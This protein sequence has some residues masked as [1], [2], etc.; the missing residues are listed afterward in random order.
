MSRVLVFVAVLM[1]AVTLFGRSLLE[2][3][4]SASKPTPQPPAVQARL[5]AN[6]SRPSRPP[7]PPAEQRA[8]PRD[9][10]IAAISSG[11]L[12]ARTQ[13][14][15]RLLFAERT[16]GLCQAVQTELTK[17]PSRFHA[18]QLLCIR[19]L[20]PG[21]DV[22]SRVIAAIPPASDTS[23]DIEDR[24]RRDCLLGAVAMRATEAPE[25]ALGP[26]VDYALTD[27][28][29]YT[30][31]ALR[32]LE[33]LEVDAL[34]AKIRAA[35]A[36]PP[37]SPDSL[38]S[39]LDLT[40]AAAI[41]AAIKLNAARIAPD[42]LT[43]ALSDP[44]ATVRGMAWE[45]LRA[46]PRP[47]TARF[48]A[49]MVIALPAAA[50][51]IAFAESGLRSEPLADVI[52]RR[53]DSQDFAPAL[54]D[55]ALDEQVEH[56]ARLRALELLARHGD[57]PTMARVAA[58]ST[59]ADEEL[60]AYARAAV[61]ERRPP[62][63][64]GM[65]REIEIVIKPDEAPGVLQRI[66]S[67]WKTPDVER[68]AAL[69][70][71]E[72]VR[73]NADTIAI[74]P[75]GTTVV[76]VSDGTVHIGDRVIPSRGWNTEVDKLVVTPAG[77]LVALIREGDPFGIYQLDDRIGRWLP[78]GGARGASDIVGG[79]GDRLYAVRDGFGRYE[80]GFWTWGGLPH[81]GKVIAHPA[82]ELVVV[83]D[84]KHMTVT[85]DGGRTMRPLKVE[86]VDLCDA[87]LVSSHPE[88]VFLSEC[89]TPKHPDPRWIRVTVPR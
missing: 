20:C 4:I 57:P 27:R 79:P 84:G 6:A 71:A 38:R 37:P 23:D 76:S 55:I 65:N 64:H 58:L 7:R 51:R 21:A 74:L 75:D 86:G 11:D 16:P 29:A 80:N 44:D 54:G 53:I 60:A 48:V 30:S 42:V 68:L 62:G 43:A 9:A 46:S 77:R 52:R 36:L 34:P 88:S 40:R 56:G 49:Q 13:A 35:V 28:F 25:E 18:T 22:L 47:D 19:A 63:H 73:A 5:A 1:L 70:A 59:V 83:T 10:D 45:H 26:L 50:Y 66:T 69:P 24:K 72:P 3:T 14:G 12:A 31:T 87:A 61:A 67:W 81:A 17:A 85:S 8:A 41:R 39:T 32:G 89:P 15:D 78:L 2:F 33:Q 82:S